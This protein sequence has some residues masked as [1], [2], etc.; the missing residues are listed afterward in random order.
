MKL[1]QM[2]WIGFGIKTNGY[3]MLADDGFGNLIEVSST[4]IELFF[5]YKYG[6]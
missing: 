3:T 4:M 2:A 6:W 5:Y 1:L